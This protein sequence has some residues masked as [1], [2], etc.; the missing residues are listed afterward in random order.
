[1]AERRQRGWLKREKRIQGE[2]WVLYFRTR[3]KSDGRRVEN[4]IP[5][6]LVRDLP[7]KERAWAEVERLHLQ[8]N[9]VDLRRG[10]TFA[11][12]A[13]HY[14]EHELISRSESI[15]A[16]AHTTIR[17]Y[18]RV[19]RNL[20]LP[21]W[22]TRIALG[23]EPLEVEDWLTTLKREEGLENPTLDRMRCA[24]SMVYRHGQQDSRR[25]LSRSLV[26]C[27]AQGRRV[28]LRASKPEARSTISA[29]P[30]IPPQPDQG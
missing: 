17:G 19:L 23:I 24:M 7:D 2:T 21:R 26:H 9:P 20:L 13:L 12:L 16:K 11:D 29:T 3:R 10:V 8:L 18:E 28:I 5:V 25:P 27:Q 4:K 14:A 1:M 15:H 6:G 30:T 22:G